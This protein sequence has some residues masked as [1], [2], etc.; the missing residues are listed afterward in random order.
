MLPP[1][2]QG[3]HE[4]VQEQLSVFCFLMSQFLIY[5]LFYVSTW[6]FSK[7]LVC[8]PKS[9]SCFLM[10]A[11]QCSQLGSG[12]WLGNVH[13]RNRFN[14]RERMSE[15]HLQNR[16]K[17]SDIKLSVMYKGNTSGLPAKLCSIKQR[18]RTLKDLSQDNSRM[19]QVWCLACCMKGAWRAVSHIRS[20][21]SSAGPWK[22]LAMALSAFAGIPGPAHIQQCVPI[23]GTCVPWGPKLLCWL[24]TVGPADSSECWFKITA[25]LNVSCAC[26]AQT[27]SSYHR[28]QM[29]TLNSSRTQECWMLMRPSFNSQLLEL[30]SL[31]RLPQFNVWSDLLQRSGGC[32]G[33][34]LP[35][36]AEHQV[37]WTLRHFTAQHQ[38]WKR[39]DF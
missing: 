29:Y 15:N 6:F 39:D 5:D 14:V 2:L 1:S 7:F 20:N 26:P 19:P 35:S 17:W 27:T 30:S 25:I 13:L 36:L 33:T 12:G 37:L 38:G 4:Q 23:Q 22:W 16:E 31:T 9:F 28:G 21:P 10:P 24:C 32:G 34:K 11:R 8:Q 18:M 3:C